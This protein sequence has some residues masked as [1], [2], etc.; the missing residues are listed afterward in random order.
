MLMAAV[1]IVLL[2]ACVNL[3]NLLLARA[4][5][6]D[7][8]LT[9]RSAL[10]AS[11]GRLVRQLLTESALLAVLGAAVGLVVAS[12]GSHVLIQLMT[13][14]STGPDAVNAIAL[15]VGPNW[16]VLTF[17]TL[18]AVVT[19]FLFG[20]GPA[21]RATYTAS[22]AAMNDTSSRLVC[23]EAVWRAR[24]SPPRWRSRCRS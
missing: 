19:T 5:S 6:R 20:M 18:A 22:A 7:R 4:A 21:W 2:I 16:R 9:L 1:G 11:R 14:G 24:L 15:D 13:T 12:W 8:E 17:A 3:A 23:P 10:G